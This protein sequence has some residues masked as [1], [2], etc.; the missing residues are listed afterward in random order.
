MT[1]RE[2][3]RAAIHHREPDQVPIDFGG[4]SCT[5][6]HVTCVAAL[7][8]YYGLEKRPV[9]VAEPYIMS[10]FFDE[11]LR[12]AIGCDVLTVSN[13]GTAFGFN[14]NNWK[15]WDYFGMPV[16]VPEGF[17]VTENEGGGY[18]IYPQGDRSVPGAGIQPSCSGISIV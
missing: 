8:E 3:V 9:K 10:G 11:D 13:Y 18:D 15:E 2:R 17:E 16:L 14:H 1:S 5:T 12:R 4:I 6:M 7:R